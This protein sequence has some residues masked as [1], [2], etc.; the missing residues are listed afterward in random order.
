MTS[1]RNPPE[2]WKRV[3]TVEAHTVDRHEFYFDPDDPLRKGC[4]FRYSGDKRNGTGT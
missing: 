2:S 4:F 1:D 3:T